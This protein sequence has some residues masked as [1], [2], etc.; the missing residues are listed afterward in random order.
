MCNSRNNMYSVMNHQ[1]FSDMQI[2]YL[3]DITIQVPQSQITK[4]GL[5]KR[6]T[7][8][9]IKKIKSRTLTFKDYKIMS[10][11]GIIVLFNNQNTNIEEIKQYAY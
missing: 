9:L 7:V 8:S 10:K 2:I 11:T 4:K 3:K 6:N 5:I 1:G